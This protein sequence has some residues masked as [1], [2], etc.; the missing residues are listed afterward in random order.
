MR[1]AEIENLHESHRSTKY[2]DMP[3]DP[4]KSQQMDQQVKDMIDHILANP[5]NFPGA[6]IDRS[7]SSVFI[8]NLSIRNLN[9]AFGVDIKQLFHDGGL[10]RERSDISLRGT[11]SRVGLYYDSEVEASY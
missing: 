4:E 11:K 7:G 5:E 3:F 2:S 8:D 9:K 6:K 10:Y 1:I